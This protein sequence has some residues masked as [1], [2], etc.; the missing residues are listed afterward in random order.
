MADNV[1]IYNITAQMELT[2]TNNPDV[3]ATISS[4]NLPETKQLNQ[5]I[6]NGDGRVM[7]TSSYTVDT[8]GNVVPIDV[9]SVVRGTPSWTQNDVGYNHSWVSQPFSSTFH[10][11]TQR[12]AILPA[13]DVVENVLTVPTVYSKSGRGAWDFPEMNGAYI[14]KPPEAL[15][16]YGG[17]A[18]LTD[19]FVVNTTSSADYQIGT[20][21]RVAPTSGPIVGY[22]VSSGSYNVDPE[23]RVLT[24]TLLIP[25]G[26]DV[27]V[28]SSSLISGY[29]TRV[30]FSPPYSSSINLLNGG[31]FRLVTG[32]LL[33]IELAYP[34]TQVPAYYTKTALDVN[35]TASQ[36][37]QRFQKITYSLKANQNLILNSLPT[38]SAPLL[39][40]V[41]FDSNL[42]SYA[43]RTQYDTEWD[44]NN[45][46]ALNFDVQE[47]GRIRD[48]KLWIELVS[49]ARGRAQTTTG[50]AYP[51][52][53]FGL[54]NVQ[55][56]LVSPNV[57]FR[58]AHPLWNSP[59]V[60]TFKTN[61]NP[62][63]TGTNGWLSN[64][65]YSYIPR[66]LRSSY[67]LWD[68]HGVNDALRY[69]TSS[70]D[71]Y[72]TKAPDG[73]PWHEFDTDLDMRTIFW[74]ASPVSNPRSITPLFPFATEESPGA[75]RPTQS[76]I[77][78]DHYLSPSYLL[79]RNFGAS[80]IDGLASKDDVDLT[81]AQIPWFDDQKLG[82]VNGYSMMTEH[83]L[84]QPPPGWLTGPP[85]ALFENWSGSFSI[86]DQFST[87][88]VKN[89][90]GFAYEMPAGSAD[91][92]LVGGNPDVET[93]NR[94]DKIQLAG[95][96]QHGQIVSLGSIPT[97]AVRTHGLYSINPYG[98]TPGVG[99][100]V[101]IG[102]GKTGSL[103]YFYDPGSTNTYTSRSI[104]QIRRTTYQPPYTYPYASVPYECNCHTVRYVC[105]PAIW[106]PVQMAD[107]SKKQARY[108]KPGDRVWTRPEHVD[109][110]KY[111][112]YLVT[113]VVKQFEESVREIHFDD[114]RMLAFS[115]EHKLLRGKDW[116]EVKNLVPGDII[117]GSR[118]GVVKFVKEAPGQFVVRI[119]VSQAQTYETEGILSH[120]LPCQ[121]CN[122]NGGYEP[123]VYC[124]DVVCSTCYTQ[125]NAS[126]RGYSIVWIGGRVG[127]SAPAPQAP[128]WRG[129]QWSS[130]DTINIGSPTGPA[131]TLFRNDVYPTAFYDNQQ[132]APIGAGN[133]PHPTYNFPTLAT[134]GPPTVSGL[135]YDQD[136]FGVNNRTS[137]TVQYD[138]DWYQ[139]SPGTSMT[140]W[141]IPHLVLDTDLTLNASY[142]RG[143]ELYNNRLTDVFTVV[144]GGNTGWRPVSGTGGGWTS[145][146]LSSGGNALNG[147]TIVEVPFCDYVPGRGSVSGRASAF[148]SI[149][150]SPSTN[151]AAGNG[152]VKVAYYYANSPSDNNPYFNTAGWISPATGSALGL[153]DVPV[154]GADSLP[155]AVVSA[156]VCIDYDSNRVYVA[157]GIGPNLPGETATWG[158][159]NI[160]ACGLE[161]D[162]IG[163]IT[164]MPST[165]WYKAGTLPSGSYAAESFIYKGFYYVFGGAKG[166]GV[167]KQT[168]PWAFR[169]YIGQSGSLGEWTA[170]QYPMPD[171]DYVSGTYV[172]P[173]SG[174]GAGL[175]DGASFVYP[176]PAYSPDA[177]KYIYIIGGTKG[178]YDPTKGYWPSDYPGKAG[179]AGP[180]GSMFFPRLGSSQLYSAKIS[181]VDGGTSRLAAGD[182]WQTAGGQIGP[183]TIRPAYPLLD[184]V[185]ARFITSSLQTSEFKLPVSKITGF[186]P[187]LK[188]TEVHG[189][190]K[191]R[192]AN[193]AGPFDPSA[194]EF[195][196]SGTAYNVNPSGGVWFRQA[197]LEFLIDKG[198]SAQEMVYPYP[199]R[200]RMY[201]R[202]SQVSVSDRRRV[203]VISGSAYWD[204]GISYVYS[205]VT[206]EYGRSVGITQMTGTSL[207]G[208][209]VFTRLTGALAEILSSSYGNSTP[210]WYLGNEFGTP[211]IP[212]SS[213][214]NSDSFD[215]SALSVSASQFYLSKVTDQ[216][217]TV[218]YDNTLQAYLNRIKA[219]RTT[220]Q[221]R[222]DALT[223]LDNTGSYF[224]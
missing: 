10:E 98:A 63:L 74:D 55:L 146:D 67:L 5:E 123:P 130:S 23:L 163:N 151:A 27:V 109:D 96:G 197:R 43:N 214:T 86:V 175:L 124:Y 218:P 97:H 24:G 61:F 170:T 224:G 217:P 36:S 3:S 167:D 198:S 92:Y 18:P 119:G 126:V 153:F 65:F 4:Q 51:W 57:N 168:I 120:N 117:Q 205:A 131:F 90:W 178:W 38:G 133:R 91:L 161:H 155:V 139:R 122:A 191:L 99:F 162:G 160:W 49:D 113:S 183:E 145:W 13:F 44:K 25:G 76:L 101:L 171:V 34:L 60:Q 62:N 30:Y 111:D 128:F 182:E 94:I 40:P 26:N 11:I 95:G 189:I 71:F 180:S 100:Q 204:T 141:N 82:N 142:I 102:G 166:Q 177:D 50:S 15:Y 213:G 157:G 148:I 66:T 196:G 88:T 147:N 2:V 16:P 68:G 143:T 87:G 194:Q 45:E 80:Y 216:Q 132:P 83:V 190:W 64:S 212:I 20:H 75:A 207:D 215:T 7:V 169:A 110:P 158:T 103:F 84:T 129:Y 22:D 78:G 211:Y 81:G 135:V 17:Y 179:A 150:G 105:S 188:N 206:Q 77:T 174:T 53:A 202:S 52:Q 72:D 118:P 46:Y 48:V 186:R 37:T 222:D 187:G 54:Q 108:L 185:Y 9:H 203:D 89:R 33:P 181:V 176:D 156:S 159:A 1:G 165:A 221:I 19:N 29:G 220:D 172:S 125:Y 219:I 200:K 14:I 149:G 115:S 58:S 208:F 47:Y 42:G 137:R 106:V 127:D 201:D 35:P 32:T 138:I 6:T 70:G 134:S 140:D 59:S 31:S 193:P 73:S 164:G 12:N 41:L 154:A 144:I 152:I 107:G 192:I 79:A 112:S 39:S 114:G 184:D 209:A 85:N 8:S 199:S 136:T 69:L 28:V 210:S 121:N 93:L 223:A 21:C 56:T 195:I 116:V 104:G 173:R